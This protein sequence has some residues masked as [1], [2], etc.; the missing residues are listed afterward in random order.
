M[1]MSEQHAWA[2]FGGVSHF[3]GLQREQARMLL[4]SNPIEEKLMTITDMQKGPGIY[5]LKTKEG[6]DAWLFPEQNPDYLMLVELLS[7]S[8][9]R[10]LSVSCLPSHAQP[11]T[12]FIIKIE[13]V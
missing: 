7:F 3:Y 5:R 6:Y 2:E 8:L 12:C 9:G 4:N 1:Q 13:L 11:N 10:P